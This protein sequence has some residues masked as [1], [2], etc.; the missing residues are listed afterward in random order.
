[1]LPAWYQEDEAGE[2]TLNDFLGEVISKKKKAE[3][4]ARL[5]EDLLRKTNQARTQ[6]RR[7]IKKKRS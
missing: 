6:N 2:T 3:L 7:R 4:T 1:V 5:A